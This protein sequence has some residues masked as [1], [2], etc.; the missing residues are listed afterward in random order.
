MQEYFKQ[1]DALRFYSVFTVIL[2]HFFVF[3]LDSFNFFSLMYKYLP[4]VPIFF[5]ISGFLIT[6]ILLKARKKS[7][8]K[9]I[10]KNFYIRR[11]FRIFPIY[12]LTIITL[13]IVNY[14]GSYRHD[15]IWDFFYLSNVH[16]SLYGDFG[17]FIAPHFWSLSVEEQFYLFWP[18]LLLLSN[19]KTYLYCVSSIT[20]LLGLLGFLYFKLSFGS[21]ITIAPLI[22][23]G[24]GTM[25]AVLWIYNKQTLVS[26]EKYLG[27][28]ILIFILFIFLH[29]YL[30]W[31]IPEPYVLVLKVL[32]IPIIVLK[33]S[34]GIKNIML[35]KIIEFPFIIY[36]GK[37]SYGLYIFHL[38]AIIPATFIKKILYLEILDN[39]WFMMCFK[40]LITILIASLSWKLIEKP[41]N[42]WKE[43]YTY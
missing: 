25:L 5:C 16:M 18:V 43:K 12:Y 42:S 14:G 13:F 28:I 20:P 17:R 9:K 33:F 19:N 31:F 36:L 38:F 6:L 4:G 26:I 21:S 3:P 23:L 32:L 35:Q 40:I 41:I 37:I 11:F 30:K 10:I 29:S 22:Y 27:G 34:L 7:S 8:T 39:A 15:F 1:L 24:S 2:S